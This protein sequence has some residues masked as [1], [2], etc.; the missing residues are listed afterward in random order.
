MKLATKIRTILATLAFAAFALTATASLADEARVPTTTAEHEA[1]AKQYRDQAAQF[2]KVADDHR[3]MVEAYKK[4]IAMPVNKA[5]QKNPWLV[6]ME[7]H[8]AML[9]KD[10][11]KLAADAEKAADYHTAR[12]KELQ[13]K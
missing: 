8:C 2:K 4:S 13:G 1:L 10:A 5:G 11:D 12:G 7:K 6:K 9:A 3:A